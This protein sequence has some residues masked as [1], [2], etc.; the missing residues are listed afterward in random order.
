MSIRDEAPRSR[1][2][3]PLATPEAVGAEPPPFPKPTSEE[4]LESA[5][6]DWQRRLTSNLSRRSDG[7]WDPLTW[8]HGKEAGTGE[9][10]TRPHANSHSDKDALAVPPAISGTMHSSTAVTPSNRTV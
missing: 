5:F 3:E 6:A 7:R 1:I 9:G 4:P 8:I 10:A 2:H